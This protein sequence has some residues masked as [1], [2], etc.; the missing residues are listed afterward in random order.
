[1]YRICFYVITQSSTMTL[2]WLAFLYTLDDVCKLY[3]DR[4]LPKDSELYNQIIF[5]SVLTVQNAISSHLLY[6]LDTVTTA[7][8]S[9]GQN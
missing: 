8:T 6:K 3:K 2:M 9:R 4:Y 5:D 1:M 7:P